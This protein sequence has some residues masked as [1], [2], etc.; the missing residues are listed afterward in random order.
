MD[1]IFKALHK[2]EPKRYRDTINALNR[3]K[4]PLVKEVVS[5]EL[6]RISNDPFD[7]LFEHPELKETIES[8]QV[9]P[10][11]ARLAVTWGLEGNDDEIMSQAVSAVENYGDEAVRRLKTRAESWNSLSQQNR[12][13][14]LFGL[15]DL[16][17]LSAAQN[18]RLEQNLDVGKALT[19]MA[20]GVLV[21]DDAALLTGQHPLE[22]RIS[23]TL[24]YF[25]EK[26]RIEAIPA[27]FEHQDA[28]EVPLIAN[29]NIYSGPNEITCIDLEQGSAFPIGPDSLKSK[30]TLNTSAFIAEKFSAELAGIRV[31]SIES[32]DSGQVTLKD[33]SSVPYTLYRY[34]I[35]Q[36]GTAGKYDVLLAE[37]KTGDN[38][39]TRVTRWI[40][41]VNEAGEFNLKH[42]RDF[43][44]KCHPKNGYSPH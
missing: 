5:S 29:A 7:E 23:S 19:A 32:L 11:P 17:S 24:S 30:K 8:N 21:E 37:S 44:K 22:K 2:E 27:S 12:C 1:G 18:R 4:A 31:S 39:L 9:L 41:V 35:D 34:G 28:T 40:V 33:G 14:L 36:N 16:D 10:H 20:G 13:H 43:A 42:A 25:E 38:F 15:D 3:T 26:R 6:R